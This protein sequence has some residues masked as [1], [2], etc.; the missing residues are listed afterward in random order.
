MSEKYRVNAFFNGV[1]NFKAAF[2]DLSD[3]LVEWRELR[4]PDD[5]RPGD[6]RKTGYRRGN[7]TQGMLL[8]SNPAC[9]EGGYQIDRVIAD[10]IEQ[11]ELEREGTLLCAGRE[12]GDETRRGPIRCPYRVQY[13]II[14]ST[15]EE[16]EKPKRFRR[17][18]RSNRGNAA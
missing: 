4:G 17:R 12:M 11:G 2:P 16:P 6:V 9:H 10:M 18:R 3:A 15:R 13:K 14:I 1:S 5:D 7:F 8:C